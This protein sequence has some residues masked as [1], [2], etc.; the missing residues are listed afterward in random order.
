VSTDQDK[1]RN[2]PLLLG[3]PHGGPFFF[4]AIGRSTIR[5]LW[6][7]A[8]D[9]RRR[10]PAPHSAYFRREMLALAVCELKIG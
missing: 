5:G 3:W 10:A 4:E 8:A 6:M 7:A 9:N 1:D 2:H